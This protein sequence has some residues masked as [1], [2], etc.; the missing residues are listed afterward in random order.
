MSLLKHQEPP[1]PSS[2]LPS[3]HTFFF[4]SGTCSQYDRIYTYCRVKG[5]SPKSS[6][7]CLNP[8]IKSFPP[9]LVLG[10]NRL[11]ILVPAGQNRGRFDCSHKSKLKLAPFS[12]FCCL[13]F[14]V[15][16]VSNCTNNKIMN[17]RKTFFVPGTVLCPCT[18]R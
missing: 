8:M 15:T 3:F 1:K 18:L 2:P 13:F 9:L 5:H 4:L 16:I 17:I 7:D 6:I 14:T 10:D 11:G 12:L